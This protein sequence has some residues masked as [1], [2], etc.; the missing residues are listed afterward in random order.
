MRVPAEIFPV[1]KLGRIYKHRNDNAA[2]PRLSLLDQGRV[3]LMKV[4]HR[5]HKAYAVPAPPEGFQE[6]TQFWDASD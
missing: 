6:D 1:C 4:A 5:R 3:P 2:A